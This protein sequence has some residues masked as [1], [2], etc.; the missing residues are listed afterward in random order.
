[1]QIDRR[2][3]NGL[4]WAGVLLV[5]GIPTADILSAQFLGDPTPA[6]SAQIA[7]IAVVER[8]APVP[9]PLSQRPAAPVAK[10]EAQV[11]T[12]TPVK[13]VVVAPPAKPIVEAAAATPAKPVVATP[14]ANPATRTADA[15]NAWLDSGKPLP[16]YITDEP[17]AAQPIQ[18][19][20]TPPARAPIVAAPTTA[21][22]AID[23][24]QVASIQQPKVAPM[25]MPLSM[26][27]SPVAVVR[28]AA[29]AVPVAV[30]GPNNDLIVAT[31]GT[32]PRP[33]ANINA[34]ELE[35]WE[36]GPLAEFLAERQGSRADVTYDNDGFFLDEGPNRQPRRPGRV[37]GP[38]DDFFFPFFE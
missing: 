29:N 14:A 2:V 30:V 38:V 17:S 25:P 35:D 23:P 9:A 19:A 5:V 28:P 27:P 16:S 32:G 36:S 3:T 26:R 15:V 33:P 20:A 11:A 12:A 10:P 6:P 34:Q 4:A 31:P 21:P 1:M 13:P 18:V 22:A 8:I 7:Q 37:I 24:V